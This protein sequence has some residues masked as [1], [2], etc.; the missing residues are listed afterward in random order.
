MAAGALELS[1]GPLLALALDVPDGAAAEALVRRTADRVDVFKVGLQLFCAEGPAVVRSVRAA[2]ARAIFLDLKL[3][4]IPNTVAGAVRSLAAL[5]VD[6]LT[7]HV[8]GGREM[9]QAATYEAPKGLRLLGVTVLTSLDDAA[10]SA[11]GVPGSP[12]ATVLARARLARESGLSGLVCS[13][14]ELATLRS[15]LGTDPLL[16][17][18]GIR[19]ASAAGDDQSRV[20]TPAQAARDGASMLVLGRVVTAA[21]DPVAALD[22]VRADLQ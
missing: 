5:G 1:A 18:P 7:V 6:Y 9:L 17:T 21:A 14:L 20:A 12:Q 10:L 8:G 2:G 11:V 19:F 22:A 3:H 13:P 15:E 16:V 4:D